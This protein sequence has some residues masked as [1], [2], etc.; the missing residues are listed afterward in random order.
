MMKH[1][2]EE[3][4]EEARH[5]TGLRTSQGGRPGMMGVVQRFCSLCGVHSEDTF[6]TCSDRRGEIV[7]YL[8]SAGRIAA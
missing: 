5:L 8:V 6:R 2:E 4:E 3:E 1:M 7:G